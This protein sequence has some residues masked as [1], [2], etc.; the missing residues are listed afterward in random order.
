MVFATKIADDV[1]QKCVVSTSDLV[2]REILRGVGP[3]SFTS[4][5]IQISFM[6]LSIAEENITIEQ[7]ENA[8]DVPVEELVSTP[9][10]TRSSD[11]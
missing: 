2:V 9:S 7:S 10:I 4:N 11:N 1:V 6:K 8:T 3:G 5:A